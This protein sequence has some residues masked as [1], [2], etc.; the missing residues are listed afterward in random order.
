MFN[1]YKKHNNKLYNK[2]V[3]LSR[4]K[5][6]YENIKLSDNFEIRILLIFLHL[7]IIF[8]IIK[9]YG[10]KKRSQEIFDNI[11][12]NIEY[13]IR[14]LGYGDVAVNKKMK[15]LNRIFYDILINLDKEKNIFDADKTKLI[16]KYFFKA[17]NSNTDS[18]RISKLA[19]YFSNFKD[20]CFALDADNMINGSI[21]FTYR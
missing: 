5:F 18:E 10:N 12:L 21:D 20:Y 8:R 16:K 6:F 13:H 1:F 2:L 11:F 19:D 4:N 14:E 7:A 3:E 17:E 15:T 9:K